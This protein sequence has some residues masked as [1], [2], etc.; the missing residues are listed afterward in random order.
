MLLALLLLPLAASGQS[1]RGTVTDAGRKP[2]EGVAVQLVHQETNR[3]R[4]A[5]TGPRGEFTISNLP[6]GEYRIE[7]EREGYARQ[8]RQFE[9]LLNQ[10]VTIEISLLPGLRKDT[11]QVTAVADVLRTGSA[12]LGGVVDNRQITGLP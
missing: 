3:Q 2:L 7:A 11:V 4:N 10:E 9:A 12:A 5:L 6:P 8:I 1:V